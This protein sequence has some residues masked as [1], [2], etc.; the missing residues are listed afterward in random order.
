MSPPVPKRMTSLTSRNHILEIASS[1]S[2]CFSQHPI[3]CPRPLSWS[4]TPSRGARCSTNSGQAL[5]QGT[6]RSGTNG[7]QERGYDNAIR[8]SGMAPPAYQSNHKPIWPEIGP[9]SST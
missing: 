8:R 2:K 7:G 5:H 6:Y 3:E 9:S 1:K 4:A